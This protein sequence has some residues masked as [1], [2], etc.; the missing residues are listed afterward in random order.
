MEVWLHSSDENSDPMAPM[1]ISPNNGAFLLNL[2]VPVV[3]FQIMFLQSPEPPGMMKLSIFNV[4]FI[5]DIDFLQ[6]KLYQTLDYKML[7]QAL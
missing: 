1:A 3:N 2:A 5:N 6:M 4:T 7:D